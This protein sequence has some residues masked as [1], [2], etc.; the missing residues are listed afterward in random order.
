MRINIWI[1]NKFSIKRQ[2]TGSK[3]NSPDADKAIGTS[4]SDEALASKTAIES[5]PKKNIR[6]AA[7]RNHQAKELREQ[8]ERERQEAANRRKSRVERRR[9]DGELPIFSTMAESR[10]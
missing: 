7:A 4:S 10:Y 8:R 5:T 1:R 9:A 2:R 3:S 6:G